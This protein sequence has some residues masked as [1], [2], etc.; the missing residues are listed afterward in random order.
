MMVL[1][2]I[3]PMKKPLYT[4]RIIV[5]PDGKGFH[6]FAPLLRGVHT[7]GR[8]IAEARERLDEAIQCHIEGLLK[9]K[10]PIPHDTDSFEFLRSFST[11]GSA[12]KVAYA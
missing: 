3:L 10:E 2:Y 8:T 5:E 9:D 12:V 4:F 11:F 1:C 6:A 7:Y